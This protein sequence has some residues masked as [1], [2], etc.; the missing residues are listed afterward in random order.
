VSGHL[1]V[2]YTFLYSGKVL[3]AAKHLESLGLLILNNRTE[4]YGRMQ[5]LPRAD[6][7][8]TSNN[9]HY[10]GIWRFCLMIEDYESMIILTDRPPKGAPPIDPNTIVSYMCYKRYLATMIIPNGRDGTKLFNGEHVYGQRTRMHKGKRVGSFRQKINEQQ[11]KAAISTL[12]VTM[13]Y[14]GE[15]YK[16]VCYK[17]LKVR[18]LSGKQWD[19]RFLTS[20]FIS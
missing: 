2:V 13:G 3:E 9:K 17:D 7:G 8:K 15:G 10:N 14:R 4:S 18:M 5:D 6:N 12:H 16:E 19:N 1:Q 11:L 20:L